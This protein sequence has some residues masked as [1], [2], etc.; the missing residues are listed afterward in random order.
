[1]SV[2]FSRS[3]NTGAAII[4]AAL[5]LGYISPICLSFLPAHLRGPI[6]R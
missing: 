3:R 4:A 5:K 6:I 2:V 1:L